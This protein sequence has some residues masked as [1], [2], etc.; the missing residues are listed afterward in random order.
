MPAAL[1]RIAAVLFAGLLAVACREGAADAGE[2]LALETLP[3]WS[4]HPV[5]AVDGEFGRLSALAVDSRGRMYAADAM[6]QRIDVFGPDGAH[7]AT[8]GGRGQGPGEFMGLRDLA[9]G[10]GDTL[11][12]LDVQNQR[13]S[14]FSTAG[15]PALERLV[16][17]TRPGSRAAYQILALASGGVVVPYT[18]PATS[19]TADAE[20]RMTF[21]HLSGD[22]YRTSRPVLELP[23]R[24]FLVTRDGGSRFSIGSLPY[25]REPFVRLG[26]D[27]RI[28]YAWS[29]AL[30][31]RR[32][33]IDGTQQ[34]LAR[35]P[36]PRAPVSDSDV[37]ALIDS[38]GNDRFAQMSRSLLR[39]AHDEGRL[40]ATRPALKN[41]LVEPD[42]TVWAHLV[43]PD[44]VVLTGAGGMT[45]RGRTPGAA[46]PW[47]VLDPEGRPVAAVETPF[48]VTLSVVRGN[49]AWGIETDEMGV[50][51]V[52]R[53]EVRR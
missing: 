51:R 9:V 6:R 14:V 7:L 8:I 41:V 20:R 12:A 35:I 53:F 30:D 31:L 42:G 17:L 15:A 19:A 45:Y 3:R 39:R 49:Q 33:E 13:A 50:Q 34:G 37:E 40:P 4:L 29:D 24:E 47:V 5:A 52:V 25:G 28:Y 1:S 11:F 23:E 10:R 22:G 44:D 2:P 46:S 27:D 26:P 32:Y 21:H 36:L 18:V 38:Y 48:E 16:D 43:T